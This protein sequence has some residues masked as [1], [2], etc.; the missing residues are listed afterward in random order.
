MSARAPVAVPAEENVALPPAKGDS[1]LGGRTLDDVPAP[2]DALLDVRGLK[3]HFPIRKGLLGRRAGEVRA[4][5]GVTFWVGRGET[6]GLVGESGSGKTTAGRTILRLI[7]P[8]AGTARF[9]GRDIFA[10]DDDELQRLRRRAQIVF[11]DPFGSLDPRM[12]V[13]D[14]LR[15]VLHVHRLARGPAAE[16]RIGELLRTVGLQPAHAGRYP[17]EFSGG[18]RQR[19]GIARALSVEP[20]FI[21]CDEPV[22]ALDVSVQAQVLNLLQDLQQRLG[23]AFLFIAHDLSV[24]EHVSSRIAVMYLGRIVEV[25]DARQLAARPVHPYTRALLSAVPVAEPRRRRDHIVLHGDIP[26]PAA[27]PPGCPFHPR[28]QHPLKDADC[29]RLVPPLAEK[30]PNQF[31]A[32]IKERSMTGTTGH[33]QGQV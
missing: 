18:Q 16:A 20:D 1:D 32:C 30:T 13:G 9:D 22:S 2:P 3:K 27:P 21:V 7:E 6:L 5:D 11:Q 10:M 26:N 33:G 4:V 28:C 23:L 19:I 24:I 12:T 25:A 15:E 29:A 8:T 14:T 17:H 31:A